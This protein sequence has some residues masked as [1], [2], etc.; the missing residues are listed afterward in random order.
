MNKKLD[1]VLLIDDDEAN[2]FLNAM[3]L[4][5]MSVAK[6]IHVRLNGQEGIDFLNQCIAGHEPLP[7]LIFLDINMPLVNGWEFLERLEEIDTK[8]KLPIVIVLLTT[9]LNPDDQEQ[10]KAL[11]RI[12]AFLNKPLSVETLKEIFAQFF[13][14]E[15][16]V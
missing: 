5:E 1:S 14:I 13:D 2:N 12:S 9:S 11:E 4:E 7:N 8:Q 3:V 15:L 10:A 16:A 6:K